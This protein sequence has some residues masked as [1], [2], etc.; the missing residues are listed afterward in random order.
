MPR[1]TVA[2]APQAA[3]AAGRFD[4]VLADLF[5]D[6]SRV[7]AKRAILAGEATVDGRVVTDPSLAVKAG[8]QIAVAVA[9]PL[10]AEPIGQDIPLVILHEDDD[11]IVIDKPAGMVVH[12][13][14]GSLDH[15]LVNAL[16]AHC[17]VSLS[18]IG[19]V[20]RPGIVHRLDKDTSG[21]L[22]VAKHDRAHQGLAAQF[23]AH[24]VERVYEA[25]VWGWPQPA[26]GEIIGNIGRDPRHRTKMAVVGRGGREARTGYLTVERFAGGGAPMASRLECRLATGR[27]HQIRV[28]LAHVG[29][30]LLGDPVYG[31]ARAGRRRNLPESISAFPRQALHARRLGFVHP[32]TSEWLEFDANPPGDL[33]DL[34][35]VLREYGTNPE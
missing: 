5:P 27:T 32:V 33:M 4:R 29:H 16:I 23:A 15:T 20:R 1:E 28:H 6:L 24:S 3:T 8:E 10:P 19:G 18:G 13:A 12:P 34:L 17:G 2:L 9:P 30:P 11:L 25:V 35:G 22:V 7:A 31:R 14:P 26:Q 21:V